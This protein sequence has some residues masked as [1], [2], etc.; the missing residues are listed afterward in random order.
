MGQIA[1]VLFASI[2]SLFAVFFLLC[3]LTLLFFRR[4]LQ[5]TRCIESSFPDPNPTDRAP[6]STPDNTSFDPSLLQ[7]SMSELVAA[8]N[9]FESDR[10]IGDGGFGVVYRAELHSGATTVAVKKLSPDAF[11]GIREFR[12]EMETLGK[13]RHPNIVKMLGYCVSG[14]DRILIYEFVERGS[15]D[16]W[17][18][19]TTPS[20]PPLS[21]ETR[22]RV[23]KGVANG[24]GY[25]H[26]LDRPIVHR[27]IKA[28]NVL[29]DLGFEA[30]I[31]DFGLA[32]TIE[33]V[34]AHKSTQAAG[35]M[36]YMPPEYK[37]GVTVAKV[38]GD[39]YSFGVLM[40]EV[41]TGRRPSWPMREDGGEE[42]WLV[43]WARKMVAEGKE[44]EVL[45]ESIPRDGLRAAEVAEFFEI[46]CLCTSEK[47]KER[48]P[49][50]KVIARLNQIGV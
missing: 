18:Y 21:W 8:T 28:G 29:L 12:A 16:E 11:Q 1:V 10:I 15:L 33:G 50:G 24:L 17:L 19:E 22:V 43:E 40:L 26:G 39:V 37:V 2:A 20:R 6:I 13:L 3:L 14:S 25:L 47:P 41:V 42:V 9:N 49:I 5:P 36:G 32:R 34:D 48:P 30:H 7:I 4:H 23:V 46:A 31:A 44:V 35:T 45:D 27:D 38:E